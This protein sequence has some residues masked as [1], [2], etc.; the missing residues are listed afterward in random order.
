MGI[1]T[2]TDAQPTVPD[3]R[4]GRPGRCVPVHH[5][6]RTVGPEVSAS[7]ALYPED[8]NTPAA[9]L[10]AA[11]AEMYASERA[12]RAPDRSTSIRARER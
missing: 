2:V 11:D 9:L 7:I 8:A 12:G 6:Q 5:R 4:Q 1:F 10:L 3:R